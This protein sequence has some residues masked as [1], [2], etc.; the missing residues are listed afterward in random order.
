MRPRTC[1]M[2][3][4]TPGGAAGWSAP[5]RARCRNLAAPRRRSSSRSRRCPRLRRPKA[6][7]ADQLGGRFPLRATHRVPAVPSDY[8]GAADFVL[9]EEVDDRVA[10]VLA[11][12]PARRNLDAEER[13][14]LRRL[15]KLGAQVRELR[16]NQAHPRR[17]DDEGLVRDETRCGGTKHLPRS[18]RYFGAMRIAP[19][20]GSSRQHFRCA[21]SPPPATHIPPPEP[22]RGGN[23]TILPTTPALPSARLPIIGVSNRPGAMVT[24]R[25]HRCAPARAR[26]AECHA[27]QAALGCAVRRLADLTVI[28]GN[29]GGEYD[30][31]ALAAGVGRVARHRVGRQAGHVERS[32]QVDVDRAGERGKVVRS[33]LAEDFFAVHDAGAIDHAMQ[34]AEG[35][36]RP[37]HRSLAARLVGDVGRTIWPTRRARRGQCV[38]VA[39]VDVGALAAPAMTIRAV[40]APS[41]L[42]RHADNKNATAKFQSCSVVRFDRP[43]PRRGAIAGP[44]RDC[45]PAP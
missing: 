12:R 32:D 23:G 40:A 45:F 27:D 17:V 26:S 41:G 39:L 34:R 15:G 42:R 2:T 35:A 44:G 28:R 31:A 38:A 7:G 43:S 1:A 14:E 33:L 11:R 36:L 4:R 18:P 9:R 6:A 8:L 21:R 3:R 19:S 16:R 13:R 20:D 37:I 29:R 10:V 5:A 25:M 22:N 24:T 30:H